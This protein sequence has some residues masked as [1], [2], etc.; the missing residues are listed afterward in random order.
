MARTITATLD[1]ISDHGE[2]TA[3]PRA[4]VRINKADPA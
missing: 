1:G 2:L 4:L 3:G